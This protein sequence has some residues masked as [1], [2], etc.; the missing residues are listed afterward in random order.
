MTLIE[1]FKQLS[2]LEIMF[3]ET[4]YPPETAFSPSFSRLIRKAE[5]DSL[6]H[7]FP[8]FEIEDLLKKVEQ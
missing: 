1:I 7:F 3:N 5:Q 6:Q 2:M 8:V 4:E